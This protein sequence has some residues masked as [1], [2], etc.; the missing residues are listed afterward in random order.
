MQNQPLTGNGKGRVHVT[1]QPKEKLK[2]TVVEPL[3]IKPSDVLA[4]PDDQGGQ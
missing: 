2:A 4:Q 3:P 1:I